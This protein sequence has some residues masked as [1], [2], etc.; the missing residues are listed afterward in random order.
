V[1]KV[2]DQLVAGLSS[3]LKINVLFGGE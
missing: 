1:A 3:G 2:V